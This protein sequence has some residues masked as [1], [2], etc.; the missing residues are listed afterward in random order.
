MWE[1]ERPTAHAC[2]MMFVVRGLQL[3]RPRETRTERF[4]DDTARTQCDTTARSRAIPCARALALHMRPR[5]ILYV[6]CPLAGRRGCPAT[7]LFS[8]T[9]A[10]RDVEVFEQQISTFEIENPS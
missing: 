1:Q 9:M 4:V 3:E 5:T 8:S 7:V 10:K 2:N 6:C